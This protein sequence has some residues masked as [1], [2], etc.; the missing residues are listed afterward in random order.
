IRGFR[1]EPEEI[2]HVLLGHPG[3][4][5]AAVVP[6]TGPDGDIRLTAYTVT[7]TDP[8]P[9][10]AGLRRWLEERLPAHMVPSGFVVLDALPLTS[11]G[12]LDRRALPVPQAP[13]RNPRG[14]APRSPQEGV[15]A[16]LFAE[17]LG[18]PSVTVDDNFFELGGHSLLATRLISRIRTT[19][20]TELP[21]ATL[22]QHPTVAALTP[23]LDTTTTGHA[24]G[25]LLPLRREG[26]LPPLFCIHPGAGPSWCYAPLLPYVDPDRPV[27]GIQTPA[28]TDPDFAPE[29]VEELAHRY[30]LHL[31]RVQ[32]DGPYHLLGWSFGGLVAHAIATALRAA[33]E[34]VAFLSVVDGYPAE[35]FPEEPRPD[36]AGATED[37]GLTAVLAATDP[38]LWP[39]LRRGFAHH[40]RVARTH[41]PRRFAGDMLLV[42]AAHD[43]PWRRLHEAWDPY[44]SGTCTT[45]RVPC[46]HHDL[47]S[48]GWIGTTGPLLADALRAATT[49]RPDRER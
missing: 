40:L 43:G 27:Y 14:R 6:H 28:L 44:V 30:L 15:L 37:E 19:L 47:F 41:R 5:Q 22:F 10:T 49:P 26:T 29:S 8:G 25:I 24:T 48:P 17:V 42:S 31:R 32:P 34:E 46:G 21:L 12:K 20:H 11:H 23:H 36:T 18:V 33:G 1:I 16:G 7:A 39:S 2:Q 13:A 35:A 3:V 4:L 45:A 38:E 9:T